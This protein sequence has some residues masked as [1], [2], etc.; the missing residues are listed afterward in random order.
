MASTA[1]PLTGSAL[2][3][4]TMS[5]H[6]FDDTRQRAGV[7]LG[8]HPVAQIEDESTSGSPSEHLRYLGLQHRTRRQAGNGIEVA[9]QGNPGGG[10]RQSS[11]TASG[12]TK[13]IG[14]SRWPVPKPK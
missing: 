1:V 13:P 9:L 14:S 12:P 3:P 11:P 4:R 7:G 8:Q 6:E 5:V 2:T 10:T